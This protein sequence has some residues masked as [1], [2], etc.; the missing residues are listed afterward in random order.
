MPEES[1]VKAQP[2]HRDSQPGAGPAAPPPRSARDRARAAARARYEGSVAQSF[3]A[4]L[5]ALDFSSQIMLFGA[6][7]WCQCCPS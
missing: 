7:C 2:G 1:S 4:E 6:A 5:K 3:A